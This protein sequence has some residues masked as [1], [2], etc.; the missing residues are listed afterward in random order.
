MAPPDDASKVTPRAPRTLI[1]SSG[2]P[3]AR[4]NVTKR[5]RRP[6]RPSS[7]GSATTAPRVAAPAGLVAGQEG[8]DPGRDLPRDALA[9]AAGGSIPG[10]HQGP[11]LPM[12]VRP[13]RPAPG[14]VGTQAR[15]VWSVPTRRA[16]RNPFSAGERRRERVVPNVLPPGV[17]DA[18]T[19]VWHSWWFA[20]CSPPAA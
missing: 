1:P 8:D 19:A 9:M 3:F 11:L 10:D 14:D 5:R 6:E 4:G 20:A 16:G 18:H 15:Q 2:L 17:G 12:H 13:H 7:N